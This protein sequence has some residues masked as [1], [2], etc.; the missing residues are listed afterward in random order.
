M[1]EKAGIYL[2]SLTLAFFM[3]LVLFSLIGYQIPC[4]SEQL[5]V[6]VLALGA[7]MSASFMSGSLTSKF[8]LPFQLSQ[9]PLVVSAS[10]GIA[11]FFIVFFAGSQVLVREYGCGIVF[12]STQVRI[13]EIDDLM[14]VKINGTE[15]TRG[16]FGQSP[17]W[18]NVTSHINRGSNN[19]QIWIANG[20][21]GGCGGKLEWKIND[22]LIHTLERRWFNDAAQANAVCFTQNQTVEFH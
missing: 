12:G 17:G 1:S 22:R 2:G 15:V 3:I 11:A 10:G 16:E 21:Y 20:K 7:G 18:V 13:S 4:G 5:P 9:H 14:W 8:E 6:V 19:V